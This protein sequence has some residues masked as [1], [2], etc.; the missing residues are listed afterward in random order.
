MI[1][2]S[3]GGAAAGY[4]SNT[5]YTGAGLSTHIN[6]SVGISAPYQQAGGGGG[7]GSGGTSAYWASGDFYFSNGGSGTDGAGIAVNGTGSYGWGAARLGTGAGTGT[8]GVPKGPSTIQGPFVSSASI[9]YRGGGPG[10]VGIRYG[11]TPSSP[12]WP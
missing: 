8:N 7:Q 1:T 4:G 11:N 12:S 3:G 9:T 5:V 2:G 6:N 10:I